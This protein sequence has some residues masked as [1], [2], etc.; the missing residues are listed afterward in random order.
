[1]RRSAAARVD[2]CP[3]TTDEAVRSQASVATHASVTSWDDVIDRVKARIA[4]GQSGSPQARSEKPVAPPS[5]VHG[6]DVVPVHE[7][8]QR[9]AAFGAELS[10]DE[11][12]SCLD[13]VIARQQASLA[14]QT[15]DLQCLCALRDRL[16][17]NGRETPDPGDRAATRK[18]ILAPL[19]RERGLTATSWAKKAGCD[20]SVTLDY[21]AGRTNPRAG[22]K[23][24]LA[25]VLGVPIWQLP[26]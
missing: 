25:A 26:A 16:K 3:A 9:G 10:P 2:T 17:G 12:A 14:A 24:E 7:I 18:L 8:Q 20:R 6:T 15:A 11:I 5:A 19:L 23:H 21:L 13:D 4:V 22:S 1:M